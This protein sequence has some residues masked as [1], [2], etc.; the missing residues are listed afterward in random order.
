MKNWKES[1]EEDCSGG[2]YFQNGALNQGARAIAEGRSWRC[3]GGYHLRGASPGQDVFPERAALYGFLLGEIRGK[4]L[5]VRILLVVAFLALGGATL[6]AQ[7]AELP[8]IVVTGTFELRPG[9]SII[10]RFTEHLLKQMETKRTV[11]EGVA[12]APWFNAPFWKYL[13]PLQ[14]S[15][16]DSFQFFT[17]SYLTSDYRNTERALRDSQKQSLFD[18]Q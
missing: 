15:S 14:S 7:E 11:E 5:R 12:R 6:R 16:T 4:L 3:I 13:P 1:V 2:R 8:P 17:P 9:P 10:D 18:P